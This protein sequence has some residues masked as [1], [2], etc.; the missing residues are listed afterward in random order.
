MESKRKIPPATIPI[1]AAVLR[2][3]EVSVLVLP[4]EVEMFE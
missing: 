2:P 1:I 4:C 3:L